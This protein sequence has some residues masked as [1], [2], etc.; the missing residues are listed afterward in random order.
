MK[1]CFSE[2]K[3]TKRFGNLHL[4]RSHPR[5]SPPLSNPLIYEEFRLEFFS[6]ALLHMNSI[7][8]A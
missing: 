3:L 1:T 2:G 8:I 6:H 4:R 5:P 7:N